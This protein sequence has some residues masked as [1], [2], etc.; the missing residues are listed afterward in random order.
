MAF[1]PVKKQKVSEQV[2]AS[3]RDAIVSGQVRPSDALPSERELA[4]RFQVNRSSIREALHR[5]EAWGL[6]EIRQGNAT[7]VRDF[8]VT[9]GPELLPF[10]LAPAGA[11]DP[12]ILRDLLG[13]RSMILA[14]T[15]RQAARA[16][17]RRDLTR[18]TALTAALEAPGLSA[19]E[20]QVLDFDFFQEL[21]NLT[22]NRVLGL[23]ANTIRQVY[24]A[25]PALF[26]PL[27]DPERFDARL[28]RRALTA[29]TAGDAAAAAAA[30]EEYALG[31][32]GG[33]ANA[34]HEPGGRP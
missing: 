23:L 15:A 13:I 18:L 27:Y 22:D 31:A 21:V 9:A 2:A 10:F 25:R 20:L 12:K 6:I 32:L 16:A 17:P 28:H 24:L 19:E 1:S 34:N 30:M 4:E 11:P 7:V 14:W 26:T 29:I 3:I 33:A 8:L 5:L